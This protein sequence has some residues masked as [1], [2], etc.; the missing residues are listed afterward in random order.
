M[1]QTLHRLLTGVLTG[2]PV[3]F[4]TADEEVQDQVDE[5]LPLLPLPLSKRQQQAIRNAWSSDLSYV[6]GPPGTG[7]SH[8]I[9]ALMLSALVL[10]KRVLLV[11]HKKAAIDVVREKLTGLLGE[12]FAIYVGSDVENRARTKTRIAALIDD[13]RTHG[14]QGRLTTVKQQEQR[15]K[16]NLLNTLH[17]ADR[18]RVSFGLALTRANSTFRAQEDHVKSRGLYSD[19]YGPQDLTGDVMSSV[20]R[21][22]SEWT[23][24]VEGIGE[25]HGRRV[26]GEAVPRKDLLKTR[27]ALSQYGRS[28]R[29]T[30]L[31]EDP[32]NL[33]R[34]RA[35]HEA[36]FD[37]D[38]ARTEEEYIRV[39]LN[40]TRKSLLEYERRAEEESKAYLRTLFRRIQLENAVNALPDLDN[41]ARLFRLRNPSLIKP[42][43]Q[44]ISYAAITK[45][46]PLWLGEM[47]NIGA[48]LPLQEEIFDLAVVDE[49]SQVNIPEIVPVF[50]R[51][52]SFAVVGDSK[53]LG[54]EAAGLFAINRTF[55][56]LTWNNCFGGMHGVISYQAAKQREL[57]VSTSSILDFIVS[58]TNGLSIPQATLDE[59]YRSMPALANF[60]S[61]QFYEDDGGLKVMTEIP[62]NLGKDCFRLMEVGGVR[63]DDGKYVMR[64]VDE[65][66]KLVRRI[67]DGSELGN[68]SHLR[69]LGFESPNNYPSVGVIS[70]TT[71][72]KNILRRRAEEEIDEVLR[73]R[74]NLYIG[75]PEEFQGN[76]RD[77]VIIT[78]GVGEGQRY[79]VSFYERRT[80]F[81]VATS[82]AKK[83]TYAI[84][85]RCPPN[86]TMLRRYFG[87]FG[88]APTTQMTIDQEDALEEAPI[89]RMGAKLLWHL[90]ER[91]CESEFERLLLS[92]LHEFMDCHPSARLS[93]FNQVNTCGQKRLDFVLYDDD[94]SCSVAVEVDGP[95]HFV[96]DGRTY[97]QEH[98]DRV[99]VLRRAGWQIVHV[100]YYKWY[101]NGWL[102]DRQ[103]GS[104]RLILEALY[105]EL[106]SALAITGGTG[107][108][109]RPA[110]F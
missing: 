57:T 41:F 14:F 88:F 87:S 100:P 42:R 4:R 45:I 29:S 70:F 59:H 38:R 52:R 71:D 73:S 19:D 23:R 91:L 78:F 104:F 47:R 89:N 30:W 92:C 99:A 31:L 15:A 94:T 24:V 53:Q 97:S 74:V 64:E 110:A 25:V 54:L 10:E 62:S 28:F 68:G 26:G 103:D 75:T 77:V 48:V 3:Q 81:N 66:L 20:P 1:S 109:R 37:Y 5:I 79:A 33:H 84:I 7:K 43:M 35:H 108:R 17:K 90:D 55:E 95:D 83:Y 11:S 60:T 22:R 67:A 63:A 58:P 9:A 50:H 65:A 27:L 85:G 106:R 76:E 21:I 101:R 72:Q 36:L 102:Y 82:R 39:D 107:P 61:T 34:L 93:L 16:A 56:E 49:A 2:S 13:V 12:E 32:W 86:A 80:R 69:Q 8:T 6:Q 46:F 51:S 18:E 44:A 40:R 105:A 96:Q 98:M